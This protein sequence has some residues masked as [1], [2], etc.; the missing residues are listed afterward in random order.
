MEI[1]NKPFRVQVAELISSRY[2]DGKR[3]LS[4]DNRC[5]GIDVVRSTDNKVIKLMSDGGQSPPQPGWIILVRPQDSE[6]YAWTLYGI[7]PAGTV[8]EGATTHS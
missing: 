1:T 2:L 5:A 3:P 6:P 7:P 4:W 8:A